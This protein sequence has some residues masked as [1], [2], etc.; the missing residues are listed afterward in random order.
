[1]FKSYFILFVRNLT[2]QKSFSLINLLGLTSGIAISLII[3]LYVRNDFSHDRFHPYADRIY[4]VNQTSIWS[5]N[6]DRQL[7]RTAPGVANA[8]KAELPEVEMITSIHTPGN[9]LVSY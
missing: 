4:R 9:F 1:M 2:R 6:E 5:E 8:L 3:F 7:A